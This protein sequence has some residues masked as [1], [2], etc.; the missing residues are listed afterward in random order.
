ME[1]GHYASNLT[2]MNFFQFLK[3]LD[4]LLY[5]VVS[6][7]AFYPITLWRT[8]RHPIAMMDYAMAELGKPDEERFDDALSPPILLL[9]TVLVTHGIE[10]ALVGQSK[11][12]S[13]TSGFAGLISDDTSLILLRL[14]AFATFPLILAVHTVRKQRVPLTRASLERPFFA[15]CYGTAPFAFGLSLAA[16]FW[17]VPS[18]P[19]QMLALS[20]FLLGMIGFIVVQTAWFRKELNGGVGIGLWNALVG[21]L[22]ALAF[23]IA[24][25]WLV[26]GSAW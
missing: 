1:S 7:L 6:W 5:E 20:L 9:L 19:T 14:V 12:V 17:Q 24:L 4:D 11:L 26:G 8:L 16:T 15:Q 21:Y 13:E 23:M 25:G 3:S 22:K 18:R 10:L 2:S